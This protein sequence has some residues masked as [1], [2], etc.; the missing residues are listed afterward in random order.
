MTANSLRADAL[1]RSTL[2]DF[3]HRVLGEDAS[4]YDT[5][6]IVRELVELGAEI[7]GMMPADLWPIAAR[8]EFD[9]NGLTDAALAAAMK[10]SQTG[11]VAIIRRPDGD[12]QQLSLKQGEPDQKEEDVEKTLREFIDFPEGTMISIFPLVG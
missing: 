9:E 12:I 5:E 11:W 3:V 4:C 8:H 7:D 1:Y 6:S 10:R 2:R